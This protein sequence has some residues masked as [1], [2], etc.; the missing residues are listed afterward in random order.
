MPVTMPL[1]S[2]A[3]CMC[4]LPARWSAHIVPR[5]LRAWR[6]EA[7]QPIRWPDAVRFDKSDA[8]HMNAPAITPRSFLW[9]LRLV[10]VLLAPTMALGDS[11]ATDANA[12]TA[13]RR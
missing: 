11:A 7:P 8:M 9:A 5:R 12:R 13:I 3:R 10:M 6:S 2:R 1:G 4:L